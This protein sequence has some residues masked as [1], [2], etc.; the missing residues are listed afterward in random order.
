MGRLGRFLAI[1]LAAS[2]VAVPSAAAMDNPGTGSLSPRLAELAKPSVRSLSRAGQAAVLGVARSGPGSLARE[3]NRVLVEVRFDHGAL[4]SFDALRAAGAHVVS[5]SRRYQT[6]TASVAPATLHQVAGVR[7]V[8]AVTPTRAPIVYRGASTSTA[9]ADC[10]GGSVISEGVAQ[11]HAGGK[12]GE[13]RAKYS[14]DG[15][16]VTVGVLSDSFDQAT[17]AAD[18]SK[19]VVATH[20]E[21]DIKSGDLPGA[22]NTCSGEATP[23]DVLE[24]LPGLQKEEATDE[25]RAMLQIVH[26]VAPRASLAFA[27]A[28]AFNSEQSF[29]ENIEQLA[30]STGEGGAGAGVIVDDVS[31][32]EEPFFQDGPVAA[33]VNKVT[34]EG[35]AYFSAAGNNNLFDSSGHEIASWEAPQYRSA[36]SCPPAVES[37]PGAKG[38]NCMD[39]HPGLPVDRTFGMKVTPGAT[40]TV[41][42]QWDE[43]WNGVTTDLDAFLLNPRG[44]LIAKS[45]EDNI[46][47]TQRPVEIVQW[48]NETPTQQVV[49]LAINRFSGGSPRLKFALLEN[50]SG[51]SGAEYP[52]STGGDVVGP[53]IF[54][55]SGAASAIGV[56]AVP[57]DD[58]STPEEYS[59]RGPVTHYFGPVESTT[60]AAPLPA[61]EIIS[62]PDLVATDCGLTTF[63][64]FEDTGG[65]RFCGTSA[66]APHAAGVAALMKQA[67]PLAIPEEV[68]SALLGS[69]VSVGEYGPCA[70]GAGLVEAVGAL[71]KILAPGPPGGPLS[72]LPPESLGSGED[73]QAAGSWGSEGSL[74][75]EAPS[76]APQPPAA[77]P[78]EG[79]PRV[80]LQAFFVKRPPKVVTTVKSGVRLVFRFGASER[81]A[82]FHC[83]IDQGQ[84]DQCGRKLIHRFTVG[85]HVV[86][87]DASDAAGNI[88]RTPA[89]YRFRVKRVG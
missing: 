29:A 12:L 89:V 80:V 47:S 85:R 60:A 7:G 19:S 11:L 81:G 38:T 52:T 32:F 79:G 62:K 16:G 86:R 63:F 15:S 57:F 61:P 58:G 83:Q 13:A 20:A 8:E 50:G 31:Y 34:S 39:F 10:E 75:T 45:V 55:H 40:I 28:M 74:P 82:T 23:V 51:V 5:A 68:R 25:G 17:Q 27:T 88:D 46:G 41:D 70:V 71:E 78:T 36:G 30:A 66:A 2:A 14:V 73:A 54:G 26:D 37:L 4:A 76:V 9:L 33:A 3:R 56:G 69:A 43:P 64:S 6:I 35:V 21:E 42:L 72:C 84:F 67:E 44:D 48:T 22:L 1:A 65:W 77:P 49:Q 59:S 87:V 18:E 53:T 24:E